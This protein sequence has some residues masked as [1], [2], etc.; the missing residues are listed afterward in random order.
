MKKFK[1][2]G[3]LI[4]VLAFLV[5]T[6]TGCYSSSQDSKN[7]SPGGTPPGGDDTPK[8]S[9]NW[10]GTDWTGSSSLTDGSSFLP[11]WTSSNTVLTSRCSVKDGWF[12][13]DTNES[14][15]SVFKSG[16]IYTDIASNTLTIIAKM[17]SSADVT[18][19]GM[20]DFDF[21]QGGYRQRV[22]F[23]KNNTIQ[24]YDGLSSSGK[25]DSQKGTV[26]DF[27]SPHTYMV[28]FKVTNSGIETNIY[29]D[30]S[31]TP[32]VTGTSRESKS[33]TELAIADGG[34]TLYLG[35]LDWFYYTTDGTFT[36]NNVILPT[37]ITL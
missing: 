22:Q 31:T 7:S 2:C 30:G 26:D 29:V 1:S 10:V 28:S 13:F 32:V 18:N 23:T 15:T 21:T 36:P 19:L 11:G 5:M 37:G 16:S 20:V 14:N 34:G 25:S 6:I 9:A 27:S 17:K 12:V 8:T 35:Y 4:M 3:W 33:K 24:I